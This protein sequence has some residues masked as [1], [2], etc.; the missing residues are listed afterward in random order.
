MSLANAPPVC[1]VEAPVLF[2]KLMR[3]K[4]PV[5][6]LCDRGAMLMSQPM[7]RPRAAGPDVTV[8]RLAS[9]LPREHG[10]WALALEPMAL[11][12]CAAFSW[13]GAAFSVAA[14]AVFLARRPWWVATRVADPARARQA[15]WVVLAL[16]SVAAMAAIPVLSLSGLASVLPL[17]V[18]ALAAAAFAWMDA[19][20]A[21][22]ALLAECAGAVAFCALGAVV[23]L[24][25]PHGGPGAGLRSAAVAGFALLRALT[26]LLP[27]R[28]YLRRRKR[29]P[30][31]VIPAL[32]TACAGV[33]AACFAASVL[34]TWVPALWAS[35][36]AL[37][38]AWLL[39]PLAP[40]WPA[41]RLGVLEAVLGA[42]AVVTTGISL[43]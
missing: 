40:A 19:Q 9:L 15:R 34:G 5:P 27:V 31:S 25:H 20:G 7:H 26:S 17:S 41:R 11:A 21:S 33:A 30:V 35:V 14:L 18:A 36:F 42:V 10:G 1:T 13:S 22:R 39:G 29:E 43:S 8:H 16:A 12:L 4:A 32:A 2:A 23:V 6:P 3:I 38:T 37:R 24:A 28:A